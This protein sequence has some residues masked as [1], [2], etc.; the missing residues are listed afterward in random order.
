MSA[1]QKA[2]IGRQLA[3]FFSEYQDA[4]FPEDFQGLAS[5][6]SMNSGA[7]ALLKSGNTAQITQYVHLGAQTPM[8]FWPP[9][10][11]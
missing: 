1:D 6:Q 9:G 7:K 4:N 2:E 8:I 10:A 3:E 5:F 11:A